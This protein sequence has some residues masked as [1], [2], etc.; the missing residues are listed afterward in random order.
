MKKLK[1]QHREGDI[2][3]ESPLQASSAKGKMATV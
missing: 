2:Y 3:N 1:A